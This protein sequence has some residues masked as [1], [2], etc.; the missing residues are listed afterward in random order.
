MRQNQ[1]FISSRSIGFSAS[2]VG[3]EGLLGLPLSKIANDL[4][5]AGGD[6]QHRAAQKNHGPAQC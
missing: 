2:Q 3:K 4:R 5:R 1:K 6:G